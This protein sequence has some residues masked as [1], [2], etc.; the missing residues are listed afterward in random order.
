MQ[1]LHSE[2]IERM[3]RVIAGMHS[4][5]ECAAFFEDLCTIREIQNMAKRLDAAILLDSGRNYQEIA[6][7]VGTCTAT[8]TRVS[9]NVNYGCGGLRTVL[10]R[11]RAEVES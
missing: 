9:K 1:K 3:Y 10:E 2:S 7:R 8:V 6:E 5:A 11:L 4:E